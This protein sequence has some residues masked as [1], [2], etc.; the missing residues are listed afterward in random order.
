MSININSRR[1]TKAQLIAII[2]A[3]RLH[4]ASLEAKLAELR[5]RH[6]ELNA[7]NVALAGELIDAKQRL[8]TQGAKLDEALLRN[9]VLEAQSSDVVKIE[10]RGELLAELRRLTQRGVPCFM[11]GDAILHRR[12]KALLAQVGQ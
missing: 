5:S 1:T 12:T 4:S 2:E 10:H 6:D 3:E 8:E 7:S 11:H 9:D